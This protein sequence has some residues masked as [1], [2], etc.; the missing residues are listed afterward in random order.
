MRP[1][2]ALLLTACTPSTAPAAPPTATGA[3][4]SSPDLSVRPATEFPNTAAGRR[5]E[6]LIGVFNS[7]S[8]SSAESFVSTAISPSFD[9]PQPREQLV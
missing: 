8:S 2:L 7:T 4:E 9:P 6:Q 1:V 3:P 5:L